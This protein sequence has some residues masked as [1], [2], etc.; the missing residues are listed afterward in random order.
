MKP[1][2]FGPVQHLTILIS[3]TLLIGPIARI[4]TKM[5]YGS[6]DFLLDHSFSLF[7]LIF[8]FTLTRQDSPKFDLAVHIEFKKP[9]EPFLI[10]FWDP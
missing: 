2:R 3:R 7:F 4:L 8:S 1:Q 9:F 10:L 5:T 6:T